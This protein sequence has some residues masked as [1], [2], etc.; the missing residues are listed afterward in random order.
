[1][2]DPQN[3]PNYVPVPPPASG[4]PTLELYIIQELLR[5]SQQLQNLNERVTTLEP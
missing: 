1:M 4:V 2:A 5:V 3:S